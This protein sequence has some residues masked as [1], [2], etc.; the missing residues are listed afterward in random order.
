MPKTIGCVGGFGSIGPC[1]PLGLPH[2]PKNPAR[3]PLHL[4]YR[5]DKPGVYEVRYQGYDFRYPV[6][7]HV[8]ARSWWLRFEVHEFP[9][10]RRTGWLAAIRRTAPSDP[11]ELLSDFLPSVLALPDAGALA[12]VEDYLYHSNSLVRQYS[13]YA[14]YGFDDHLVVQH[15]AEVIRKRGPTPELAYYLSWRRKAFQPQAT[16][17]MRA[18]LPYLD[19]TAPLL[20]SGALQALAFLKE[21]FDWHGHPQMPG[22][23][24]SAV[25]NSAA[26]LMR[27]H[28]P[29]TLRQLAEYLGTVRNDQSR[30]L[31][32]RLVDDQN[33]REQALI[34]LTWIANP[35]DLSAIGK[36]NTGNLDEALTR[37]YGKAAAP[38]LRGPRQ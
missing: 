23:M 4:L 14:L 35:R 1:G 5:F 28:N 30:K 10:P 36:Y 17:L 21:H 27:P 7:R 37:A 25:L 20:S 18:V 24:D 13:L 15:M 34:S 2:E 26:R 31:L 6:E 22:V 12:I 8:L 9:G 16:E 3:L 19:A 29:E 11:V 33:V 38:Y 32:W